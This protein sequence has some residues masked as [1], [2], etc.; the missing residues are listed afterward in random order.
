MLNPEKIKLMTKLSL[1]EG[2]GKQKFIVQKFFKS[3]YIAYHLLKSLFYFTIAFGLIIGGVIFC[4][5]ETELGKFNT[6]RLWEI[7]VV[8]ALFYLITAVPYLTVVYWVYD[9]RYDHRKEKVK[10][11]QS[12]LKRL[13]HMYELSDKSGN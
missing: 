9:T 5:V 4:L 10:I 3:D 11:Y 12:S 2:K 1:Y 6:M 7:V 8:I 13:N